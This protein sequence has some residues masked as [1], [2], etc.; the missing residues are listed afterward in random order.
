LQQLSE[1]TA[2]TVRIAYRLLLGREPESTAVVDEKLATVSTYIDLRNAFIESGEFRNQFPSTGDELN[3][4]YWNL[5]GDVAVDVAPDMLAKLLARLSG[6]WKKLGESDPYWSVLTHDDFRLQGM[7]ARRLE[8]FYATGRASADLIELFEKKTESTVRRG[9][10]LE[11][12]CG[13]GRITAR[14]AEKFDRVLAVDISPGNLNIC[15]R[16]MDKLGI[17]NVETVLLESPGQLAELGAFDFFYSVIVLQHNPPPIQK[18]LLENV[19]KNVRYG[20]GCLFQTCGSL[21]GYSFS[22]EAYLQTKEDVMDIHC[23]PKPVVLRL[24]H[25]NRLQVRDV[26]MDPWVGAFGSYTYFATK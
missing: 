8:E 11:L 2:E 21:R 9:V 5:P 22:P 15:R 1:I 4:V 10:C 24:L 23:L 7:D 17:K 13:V 16:Y 3:R 26:E 12:G 25:E 20:G 14:L 18:S 6:Q 19:L